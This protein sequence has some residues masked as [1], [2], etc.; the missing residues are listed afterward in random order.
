VRLGIRSMM[1]KGI[2]I[3]EKM[4]KIRYDRDEFMSSVFSWKG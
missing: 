3:P 4:G 2:I 1:E